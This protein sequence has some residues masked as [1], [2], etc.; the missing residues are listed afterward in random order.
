VVPNLKKVGTW[1]LKDVEKKKLRDL[2]IE[3]TK[4]DVRVNNIM[5]RAR[6]YCFKL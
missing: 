4:T 3:C 5:S 1:P 2:F 6:L